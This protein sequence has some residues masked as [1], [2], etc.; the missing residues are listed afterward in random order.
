MNGTTQ[1]RLRVIGAAALLLATVLL[2]ARARTPR[3]VQGATIKADAAKI[4]NGASESRRPVLVELFTSEGCSSC[5]PADELLQKL[6]RTQPV[7]DVQII[8]LSEHV[9]YWDGDGWRDP[10]SSHAYSERQDDY[11]SQFRLNGAYTPQMVVDGRFELVGSD[12]RRA[13]FA[14][15]NAAQDEKLAVSIRA[16]PSAEGAP[17]AHVDVAQLPPTANERSADVLIAW[18]DEADESHVQGGE[19]GGRTLTHV[20]VSR[21]MNRVG[22]VDKTK[23]FSGDFRA[24]AASNGT[25]GSRV[26]VI[27]QVPGGRVWGVASQRIEPRQ[28]S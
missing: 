6:D 23:G 24:P 21:V 2:F 4:T 18:A 25:K 3:Y 5:P 7:S 22:K 11:V 27:V 17:S 10:Y 19:N 20:A 8:V 15:E 13:L 28:N 1:V 16:V 26:I 12:E 9:D 14:I